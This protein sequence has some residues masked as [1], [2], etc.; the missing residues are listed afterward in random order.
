MFRE[1]RLSD[2][3][4]INPQIQENRTAVPP[5]RE[6]H[7]ICSYWISAFE[8]TIQLQSTGDLEEESR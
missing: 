5:P 1:R 2:F 8:K 6:L 3:S 7:W 4:Q